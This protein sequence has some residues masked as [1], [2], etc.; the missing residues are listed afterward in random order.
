MLSGM[1]W[2]GRASLAA[3]ACSALTSAAWAQTTDSFGTGA[4]QFDID[5]VTI[6]GSA[7]D[8]F[9][10]QHLGFTTSNIAHDYRIGVY[11]ITNDQWNKFKAD[12]GV[13]VTGT[14]SNAYDEG[15]THTGA[16]V[17]TNEVSWHEAAQ[18]VNWLNT[19]T[20]HQPAYKFTGTQGTAD[21]TLDAW[22][23]A[24]ADNGTNP[25][26]H[27]NAF[28]FLPTEN[29]WVK[30]AYWNGTS[31]QTFANAS[32]DDLVSGVPD[33]AKWN[34]DP[35]AGSQPWDVGSGVEELNGTYDLMG[36]VTEWMESPF[37]DAS[38]GTGSNRALLGGSYLNSDSGLALGSRGLGSP[39]IEG[40]AVGFRVASVVPAPASL[41]LLAVGALALLNRRR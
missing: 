41:S 4:N 30:A 40:S 37:S 31:L 25:F 23:P 26:R 38:F 29:E 5:F 14:P 17:P 35:S 32:P 27:K 1:T 28:Y 16:N 11:E 39:A 12:L 33:P 18:F 3:V 22:S 21:Y 9:G 20:G 6:A 13:P 36:N 19:S 10:G 34:Y 8:G 2:L 15:P 24:E 7:G